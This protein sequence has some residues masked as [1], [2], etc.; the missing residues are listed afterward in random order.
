MRSLFSKLFLFYLVFLVLPFFGIMSCGGGGAGSAS[1]PDLNLFAQN[2]GNTLLNENESCDDGNTNNSDGCNLHCALEVGEAICGNGVKENEE[3]CDDGNTVSGDGCSANCT[4]ENPN[5]APSAPALAD[6]PHNGVKW[7]PTRLYLSWSSSTDPD[8]E[9]QVVYDVY[10]V[11]GNGISP[12]AIPYKKGITQTHFIIQASTDN[13][14]EFFPDVVSPLYLAPLRTYTWKI[15]A[16]DKFG[17]TACSIQR[18]FNTDDSVVGWWRFDENPVGSACPSLLGGPAGD[19]GETVCDYSGKGNHGKNYGTPTWLSPNSTLLGGALQFDGVDDKIEVANSVSLNPTSVSL[20]VKLKITI[21]DY[22]EVIDK[23]SNGYGYN[24]R[25]DGG[26]SPMR[27]LFVVT[28]EDGEQNANQL[29]AINT[30]ITYVAVGTYEHSTKTISLYKDGILL[31]VTN[32]I[33]GPFSRN[34]PS[35]DPLEIGTRS[36]LPL[37]APWFPGIMD[38]VIIYNKSITSEQVSNAYY[39]Y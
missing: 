3:C 25:I 12:N 18:I 9:D 21:D 35:P 34:I 4:L 16:R 28:G 5:H 39:T 23:R 10:F 33:A 26:A 15:C 8:A 29:G 20:Q 22:H 27:L 6:E 32:V 11:E 1:L 30:D 13:R 19:F 17:A 31:P 2:C 37:S 36:F 14:S 24:L 38:D 7:A